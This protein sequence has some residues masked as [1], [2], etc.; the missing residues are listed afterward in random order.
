MPKGKSKGKSTRKSKTCTPLA[1][2]PVSES[3]VQQCLTFEEDEITRCT[4][5]PTHGSPPE[6][7]EVHHG[8]YCKMIQKYKDASK[9]VDEIRNGSSIPT[10]AEISGYAD[11]HAALQKARWMRQYVDAIRV[12]KTGREIHY[13]RFF[14]KG[15]SCILL[16]NVTLISLTC[17]VNG[18]H[19][20]R[21]ELLAKQMVA[22]VEVLDSIQA[23]AFELHIAKH[24]IS[25]WGKEPQP[26]NTSGG[27]DAA[28]QKMLTEK[29]DV[30]IAA[31][32][33]QDSTPQPV[34]SETFGSQEDDLIDMKIRA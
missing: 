15:T 1:P 25:T 33:G 30:T 34:S 16:D 26:N 18:G 17:V 22:A 32:T 31:P 27:L 6:R 20:M 23:Q 14:L 10:K 11:F 28:G 8:Q 4:R 21:L 9:I 3:K 2:T 13:R 24:P 19:K 12:E 5:L 7:C 29:E